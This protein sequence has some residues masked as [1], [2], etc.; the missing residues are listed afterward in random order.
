MLRVLAVLSLL[1]LIL[2][3]EIFPIYANDLWMHLLLGGDLLHDGVPRQEVYSV[4]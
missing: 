3:L 1:L 4:L 2:C